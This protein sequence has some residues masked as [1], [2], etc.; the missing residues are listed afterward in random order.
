[1]VYLFLKGNV[2][3][4]LDFLVKDLKSGYLMIG[5]SILFENWFCIVGG[6]E[7]VVF[8]MFVC[9]CELV[10]EILLNCVQ[11]LEILNIDCEF[12]DSLCIVIV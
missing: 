1:M 10:Y 11:V 3:F 7:M 5:L 2:Q 8:M 4:I 12:V 9:D 6:E